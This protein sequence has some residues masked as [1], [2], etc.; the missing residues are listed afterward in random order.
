MSNAVHGRLTAVWVN[1][2]DLSN[3]LNKVNFN[4]NA[5]EIDQTT[6][7]DTARTYVADFPDGES[8]LE[9]F[10]STDTT[11]NDTADDVFRAALSTAAEV[12]TVAPEGNTFGYR[13]L[14]QEATETRHSVESPVAGLISSM[15]N[16]R[17]PIAHGVLLA[18]KAAVTSSGNG[19]GVDNGASSA[20]G[21]VAHLHVFTV[22][23]TTPT[24][25]AKVQHSTDNSTYAD[26]ITFSQ[27]TAAGSERATVPGTVNRYTRAIRT[28]GGSSTPT[29]TYAI[30]FA[31]N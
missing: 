25:D 12:A 27:K 21:G 1:Q 18:A 2:F 5:P 22:S 31:R 9:G 11:D 30:A 24:L 10:W 15:A 4:R 26:L 3:Y 20:N 6:F 14:L 7:Q 16:F 19:T 8:S 23:G 17:G 28:I 29:F 13:A